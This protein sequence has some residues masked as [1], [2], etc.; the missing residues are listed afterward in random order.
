MLHSTLKSRT[1]R[2]LKALLVC[3]A[4]IDGANA[5]DAQWLSPAG[6]Q[7]LRAMLAGVPQ[8]EQRL[9]INAIVALGPRAELHLAQ[10]RATPPYVRAAQGQLAARG[11]QSLPPQYHQAFIDGMF[12][13]S[14]QE[15]QF[16]NQV[17]MNVE[18]QVGTD[19]H[20]A[21]VVRGY[22]ERT[23][24]RLFGA[25]QGRM[26]AIMQEAGATGGA[27]SPFT[28]Y[29]DPNTGGL[30]DGYTA[31]VGWQAYWCPGQTTPVNLPS[32]PFGCVVA[33]TR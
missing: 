21:D 1:L 26:D 30:A 10:Y 20:G 5:A 9:V 17:A 28:Q 32:Q 31:R 25:L 24:D 12:G 4:L 7:T 11:L 6:Q 3:G 22:G 15:T 8:Y 2:G 23:A 14:P 19:V 33:Q 13:V 27:L 16:A 18:Q 29:Y